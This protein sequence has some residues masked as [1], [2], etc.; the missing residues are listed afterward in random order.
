MSRL[1]TPGEEEEKGNENPLISDDSDKSILSNPTFTDHDPSDEALQKHNESRAAGG[2]ELD[3]N[4][5]NPKKNKQGA[6]G[7]LEE[8]L[9]KGGISSLAGP[10]G[11]GT[12][13]VSSLF[14]RRKKTGNQCTQQ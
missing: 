14:S 13:V 7:A 11:S 9:V 2:S 1:R 3:E 8:G 10:V 6:V 4:E 5:R 12:N